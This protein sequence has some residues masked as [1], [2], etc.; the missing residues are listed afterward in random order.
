MTYAKIS[1]YYGNIHKNLSRTIKKSTRSS[2]WNIIYGLTDD[3]QSERA[4]NLVPACE[5]GMIYFTRSDK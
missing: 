5:Q 1:T 4:E 3:S 2:V